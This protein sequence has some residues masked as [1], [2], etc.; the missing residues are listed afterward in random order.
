MSGKRRYSYRDFKPAF[1]LQGYAH[2]RA[3]LPIRDT[4]E[5][6]IRMAGCDV[7]AA[8]S[9]NHR[10]S[11]PGRQ[12]A[13]LAFEASASNAQMTSFWLGCRQC[14]GTGSG[15]SWM[16]TKVSQEAG[17][18]DTFCL[19][20]A[21]CLTCYGAKEDAATIQV[22]SCIV[23]GALLTGSGPSNAWTTP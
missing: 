18:E 15:F 22:C 21:T 16:R 20:S 17:T 12:Q 19:T 10:I 5:D 9:G 11:F 23:Q 6:P 8:E 4:F 3:A 2:L 14:V 13:Q 1:L 7:R